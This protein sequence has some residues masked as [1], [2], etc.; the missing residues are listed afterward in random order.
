MELAAL[1]RRIDQLDRRM[2]ELLNRRAELA[3]LIG[4]AKRR[5]GR[6][7]HDP[8]REAAIIARLLEANRGPLGAEAL[9]KIY[10]LIMRESRRLEESALK[11]RKGANP[12]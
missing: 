7:I 11:E 5:Q 2:L 8:E 10:R 6:E 1:R 3:R 12:K 9:S 4:R